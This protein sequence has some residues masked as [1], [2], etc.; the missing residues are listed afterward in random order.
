L[1]AAGQGAVAVTCRADDTNAL[2]LVGVLD[3]PA[4]RS[5]VL[6]ERAFLRSLEGGCQIPLGALA[7][8][9]GDTL[10][11]SGFVAGMRSGTL[12]RGERE[13]PAGDPAAIGAALADELRARGAGRLLEEARDATGHDGPAVTLP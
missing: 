9:S 13:G 10:A 8:I 7:R 5:A 1:P 12:L 3:H 4:T 2:A 11:L 6:A